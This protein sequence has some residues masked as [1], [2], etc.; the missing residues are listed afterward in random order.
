MVDIGTVTNDVIAGGFN[1]NTQR[2]VIIA[3]S[4]GVTVDGITFSNAYSFSVSLQESKNV[5]LHNLKI[6]SH[7][8]ATDG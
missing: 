7:Y 2:G 6:F 8:G 5:T 4:D 3:G 1:F